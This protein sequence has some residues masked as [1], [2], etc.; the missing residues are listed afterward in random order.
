MS[1]KGITATQKR[2]KMGNAVLEKER[3]NERERQTLISQKKS[4]GC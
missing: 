4:G 1:I 2:G 3:E